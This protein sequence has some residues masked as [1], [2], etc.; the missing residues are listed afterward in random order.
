MSRVETVRRA[1][2][3]WAKDLTDVSGRNRLLYH[4]T[5]KVGTLDLGSAGSAELQGLLSGK[6]GTQV[7]LSRLFSGGP[8]EGEGSVV[9]AVRRARSISRKA[10]E[11]FEER[12]VNTL[13]LVQGMA[14]WTVHDSRATPAAPVLMCAAGLHRRGASEVDFDLSLDGEWMVNDALLRYLAKK[15]EVTVSGEELLGSK[16]SDAHLDDGEVAEIFDDLVVGAR[17]RVPDFRIERQ[18]LIVG[19]FMYRKMPMVSDIEDN[20]EALSQHDLIAAIAGDGGAREALRSEQSHQIDPSWPDVVPPADEYLVLDADSSQNTAINAALYGESF[21]LQGPPGTGKSQT[22]ANVIATM[23]AWGRSV[24]FV[25]E[26]RAAIDAVTKRLTQVSLDGFVMDFH[27][28]TLR[29]RERA[30]RL[31]ES[32]AAIGETPSAAQPELHRRLEESRAEL[33]GYAEALRREREPWGLS[34]FEVQ[35]GLLELDKRRAETAEGPA[36][37]VGIPPDVLAR[38]DR[39]TVPDV[40]RDLRDWADLAGP[41]LEQRSPWFVSS[42][43]NTADVRRAQELLSAL[44]A[45]IAGAR[46]RGDALLAELGFADPG[47]PVAWGDLL[48]LLGGVEDIGS[49]LTPGIFARDLDRL[50]DDLASAEAGPLALPGRLFG[51]RYR[52]ARR[53][54]A[55][56]W[57]QPEKLRGRE[58]LRL[59]DSAREL[60]RRWE[61]RGG[62]G[63]A[64]TPSSL[65]ATV[66]GHEDV[67][68][69]VGELAAL[70]PE[71]RLNEFTNTELG[72]TVAAL[73]ADV[74][75]LNRLPQLF[76]LEQRIAAAGVGVLTE[77]ARRGARAAGDLTDVFERLWLTSIRREVLLEDRILAAFHQARQDRFVSEFRSDD[78]SH[79]RGN[80]A[81][82][83]RRVAER[84]VA[85]RNA[86]PGQDELIRREAAK[87]TRHLPLRRLFEQAADVLTAVRPCWA[88]SPL[89][90]AQTLP[91]RPLFDLVIFDEA[92]Q[93]LPCDAV[94]ALLRAPRAMVA[95]DSR[96][97][98]PTTFFDGAGGEDGDPEED[99]GSLADYES[100]LDVM[101]AMLRRRQLAWHYR[102]TDERLIT[103]SNRN[104]YAG[105]LT[106]FP[107]AVGGGCLDFQLVEHRLGDAS[108]TRSNLGEVQRVVDLML[109]HARRR[110]AET[111]GVIAMGSYHAER[112]EGELRRRLATESSPHLERFFDESLPE[113]AF[114]KNLER[115]QGDERDAVILSVG[116]GKNAQ[117]R[118][119]Y[120]FGP[121]NNAGGE[122][123]LNVAVTR[124]RRRM[125]LVSSFS[126]AE[127]DPARTSADGV[128]LLR[129]YLRYVDSGGVDL[130]GA[131]RAEPLNA[132]EV[133]VHDKLTGAGLSVVPQY[134]CSG[135]RIDFAVRHP[136]DPGR[137]ILAV[138]ADGA[139]YHS[140]KT[141]RDR[142]RLRQEH[143]ER[144]GWRFCRIWSTDWFN[145]HILE[146]TR[147]LE[148]C[149]EAMRRIDATRPGQPIGGHS[150]WADSSPSGNSS[151]ANAGPAV[152]GDNS[153]RDG[154]A[155]ALRFS[156]EQPDLS[157]ELDPRGPAPRIPRGLNIDEHDPRR[158]V[159]LACWVM[160]DGRLRTDE[161]TFEEMFEQMD[162][163]RRGHRIRE[164]LFKAIEEAMRRGDGF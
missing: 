35:C 100:I 7:T 11:N 19:N 60:A 28:G 155:E 117:G 89:D 110:P 29:R 102:S 127:M 151:P 126:H 43:T 133:D 116:Y 40:R 143:L 18:R 109:D 65:A 138:E 50:A 1:A 96:Q 136:D 107:G 101:D 2:D 140:S 69:L 42:V 70:L 51:S 3:R 41:A 82:V 119:L 53:E 137:F 120:R 46:A 88:M 32:L 115:V 56:L 8:D 52:A 132:F 30:R 48:E 55:E 163:T 16:L 103:F 158:L 59:V 6:P 152:L 20:L 164:A 23:M 95:G 74:Q 64:R 135:Y 150:E 86:N 144:L 87:R 141:V 81:R 124:A 63:P 108:D 139:S 160:S 91:P 39:N 94:P 67:R 121:L 79:L 113:R 37:Q 85:V 128:R 38:L 157:S 9:D 58:A 26:K 66:G 24:L 159:Q 62:E 93:V 10:V 12:G 105:S 145:N 122:R 84:A 134:G 71:H 76:E 61:E 146:V 130:S 14:T 5:L 33:S 77:E 34:F 45:A 97:L 112:I 15:F 49:R 4:R 31:D 129:D 104:I 161:E 73:A 147:V 148:A 72:E 92:S 142:D 22:I 44:A 36:E 162:Y 123:R 125:T 156:V 17:G 99:A 131:D 68:R 90:V 106:T 13:F 114:V 47:S 83:R 80:P 25:A 57:Q 149:G 27:G 98:P 153:G 154:G 54:I 118:L 78:A 75:T 21:V 111:L